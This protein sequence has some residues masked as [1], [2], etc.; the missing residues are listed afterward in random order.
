MIALNLSNF[1]LVSQF[2]IFLFPFKRSI[3]KVF[4]LRIPISILFGSEVHLCA[5]QH[6]T[7]DVTVMANGLPGLDPYRD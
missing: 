3:L 6:N 7:I 1:G 5:E 2:S 4:I